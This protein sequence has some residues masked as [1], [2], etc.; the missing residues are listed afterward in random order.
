MLFAMPVAATGV[1]NGHGDRHTQKAF[2]SDGKPRG[3]EGEL[4]GFGNEV[5]AEVV[6]RLA[7][8]QAEVR[9][10]VEMAG[11]MEHIVGPE[12]DS[13]VPSRSREADAFVHQP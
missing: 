8:H 9:P 11:S 4:P 5:V 7:V 10:L 13:L 2:A 3:S 1:G 6:M 12:R